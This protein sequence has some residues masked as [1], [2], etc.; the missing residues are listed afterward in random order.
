MSVK[1]SDKMEG[2]MLEEKHCK[3]LIDYDADVVDAETGKVLAK[4]RKG[5]IPG[6]ICAQAYTNLLKAAV[7]TDSRGVAT[8]KDDKTGM[9]SKF[10]VNKDGRVS[11]QSIANGF[12]Y[13][14]VAGFYDRSTRFPY[15]RATAFTHHELK[16]FKA[17]YPMFKLV[18]S[19]YKKL[20][21]AE[22][23]KQRAQA[24]KTAKDF[25][26]PGTS[27][28]TVT[29]NKN[30]RTAV[31]KD[32]GD[33]KEGFG[34]LVALR[35]GVYTGNHLVLPRWG[36]GFDLRNTD[37]LLMDVHQW[38][39]NTPMV[40][41]DKDAVRLSLVMYYRE[42]MISCGTMKQEVER[43]RKRKKGDKLK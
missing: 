3:L 23:A 17:A 19:Y 28:S 14:G 7:I 36:V 2:V 22:Y 5:I 10:R 11:K 1:D 40:K 42:N 24:D 4:F 8:G 32:A 34:N 35:D 20:M 30:Y 16:K 18:D 26:I 39:G 27:F 41:G 43:A 6:S 13:S 38:H 21:P 15:C 33:F 25:I 37:L 9:N 29:V 12:V 31:H